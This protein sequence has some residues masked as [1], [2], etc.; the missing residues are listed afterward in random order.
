MPRGGNRGGT[1]TGRDGTVTDS[2]YT[3]SSAVPS[4]IQSQRTSK[5]VSQS[6][7]LSRSISITAATGREKEREQN[8]DNFFEN[9]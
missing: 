3:R 4:H 2:E 5:A 9:T 8:S 1:E 7:S 6:A